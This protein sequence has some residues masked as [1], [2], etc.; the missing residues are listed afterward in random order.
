LLGG[1]DDI[2][3]KPRRVEAAN[4]GAMRDHRNEPAGAHFG[5]LLRHIIEPRLL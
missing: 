1:L 2:G 4:L 5:G 3:L